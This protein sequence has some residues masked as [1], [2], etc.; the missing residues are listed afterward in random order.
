MAF[1]AARIKIPVPRV[2]CSFRHKGQTFIVME[3]L[4]GQTLADAWPTLSTVQV[5]GI[6]TDLRQMLDE[7]RVLTAPAMAIQSCVEGSLRDSRIPHAGTRI[8]PFPSTRVFH[9]WL[10]QGLE[11]GGK[12]PGRVS[13]EEWAGIQHMMAMQDQEWKE[14]PVFTHGDLNPFNIIVHDEKI[15]GII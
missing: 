4:R 10:R 8:G 14:A 11:V 9:Q 5:E 1:I 12:N 3:R 15:S 2:H 13:D 6:L 7:L